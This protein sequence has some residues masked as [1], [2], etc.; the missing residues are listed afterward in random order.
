MRYVYLAL[1]MLGSLTHAQDE[2]DSLAPLTPPIAIEDPCNPRHSV[3]DGV[4]HRFRSDCGPRQ[5]CKPT[6]TFDRDPL[7]AIPTPVDNIAAAAAP[8]KRQEQPLSVSLPSTMPVYRPP[9][10]FNIQS[11]P[12]MAAG[13]SLVS[14][15]FGVC[16][17]KRCRRDEYPFGYKGVPFEELPSLCD[18][19]HYCPDDE[20]ECQTLILLGKICQ[21]NRDGGYK[22]FLRPRESH[23]D[24]HIR[25]LLNRFLRTDKCEQ[26]RPTNLLP[27][28]AVQ[29]RCRRI[30]GELYT[31]QHSLPGVQC[32]WP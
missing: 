15:D 13:D 7:L 1:I 10:P 5:W 31:G 17:D 11:T 21:L 18:Q 16:I 4:T 27:P 25:S 23:R 30:G 12:A 22:K 8:A 24:T 14:D 32:E 26:F 29:D 2:S 9:S 20:S 19:S 28:R 6:A 3:L